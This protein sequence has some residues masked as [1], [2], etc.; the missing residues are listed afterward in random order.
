MHSPYWWLRCA[1]GPNKEIE[2]NRLV[3]A[4]HRL[5]SWDIV[6][7]PRVTRT[8][9]RLLNPVIRKSLA[10]YATKPI[11]DTPAGIHTDHAYS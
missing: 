6:K 10:V 2:D 3:S 11:S 4:Y 8:A 7:Q 5:L 9:D 1:V